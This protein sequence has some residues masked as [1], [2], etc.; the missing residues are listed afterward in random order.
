[1]S[2]QSYVPFSEVVIITAFPPCMNRNWRDRRSALVAV[3]HHH[4]APAERWSPDSLPRSLFPVH[5]QRGVPIQS[6]DEA[7]GVREVGPVR[8]R[9]NC[10]RPFCLQLLI[11]SEKLILESILE[12]PPGRRER[13][14]DAHRGSYL[15]NKVFLGSRVLARFT[16]SPETSPSSKYREA[17]ESSLTNSRAAFLGRPRV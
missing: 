1:V 4:R 15:P 14:S 17:A 11:S 9:R 13:D 2:T 7:N 6:T 5:R 8:L 16:K 3:A 10:H 12:M